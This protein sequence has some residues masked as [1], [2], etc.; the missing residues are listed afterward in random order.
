MHQDS[1]NP[2]ISSYS[3]FVFSGLNGDDFLELGLRNGRVVY[4]Y[5]LGSGTATIISKPLDLTLNIHVIHLG[6]YLQKGWLKVRGYF[7]QKDSFQM[8]VFFFSH[9]IWKV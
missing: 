2:Q 8:K 5:N 6:R 4:S 1:L 9:F 3:V 7:L